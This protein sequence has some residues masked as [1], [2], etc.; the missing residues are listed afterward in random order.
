MDNVSIERLWRS[1]NH[2]GMHLEGLCRRPHITQWVASATP[3]G[4]TGFLNDAAV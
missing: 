1:L 3:D 4:I 2:E